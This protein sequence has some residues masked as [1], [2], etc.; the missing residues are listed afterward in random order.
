MHVFSKCN[1]KT[2]E[3]KFTPNKTL[4]SIFK[5]LIRPSLVVGLGADYLYRVV[6]PE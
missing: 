5:F 1:V 6:T 4:F 2:P 3:D